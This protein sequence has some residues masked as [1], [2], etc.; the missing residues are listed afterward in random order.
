MTETNGDFR[1]LELMKRRGRRAPSDCAESVPKALSPKPFDII[2]GELVHR[3]YQDSFQA[4]EPNRPLNLFEKTRGDEEDGNVRTVRKTLSEPRGGVRSGRPKVP[5]ILSKPGFQDEVLS[6]RSL[7]DDFWS[8]MSSVAGDAASVHTV[9]SLEDDFDDR[10][11]IKA[12]HEPGRN[13]MP[14]WCENAFNKQGTKSNDWSKLR[15]FEP[16]RS[17]PARSEPQGYYQARQAPEG[18][19]ETRS[20]QPNQP[21]YEQIIYYDTNYNR[22]SQEAPR[23]VD[24]SYEMKR[25]EDERTFIIGSETPRSYERKHEK[26][27]SS[28]SRPVHYKTVG[29]VI[30]R[31]WIA[32][33]SESLNLTRII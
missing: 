30:F 16:P 27:T 25:N 14:K 29:V 10:L 21:K 12:N 20:S 23:H 11:L 1:H 4:F 7:D 24:K 33:L 26:I 28:T 5:D 32:I 6:K 8:T 18:Y 19:I 13:A 17:A 15:R 2:N 3:T 22:Q 31:K 9:E